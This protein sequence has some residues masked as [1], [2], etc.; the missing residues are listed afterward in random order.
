MY[1]RVPALLGA[2]TPQPSSSLGNT[3]GP[4]NGGKP[5]RTHVRPPLSVAK[6]PLLVGRSFGPVYVTDSARPCSASAKLSSL[7][8]AESGS[9]LLVQVRPLSREMAIVVVA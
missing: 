9:V 7:A 5:A 3:T 4:A 2:E 8:S 1:P 6:R